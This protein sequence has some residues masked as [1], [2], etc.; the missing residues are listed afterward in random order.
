MKK[1]DDQY[2]R[3]IEPHLDDAGQPIGYWLESVYGDA[4][5]LTLSELE[6]LTINIKDNGEKDS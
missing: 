3:I 2:R 6:Q 5:Y 1:L 4:I